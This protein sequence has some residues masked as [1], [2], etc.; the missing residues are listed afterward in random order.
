[1]TP[2]GLSAHM[3]ATIPDAELMIVRGG[4]H[5][6]P[7]EFPEQI[8]QRIAAFLDDAPRAAA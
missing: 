8:N 7:V 3:V 2:D 5:Y 4:T 6:V 1:M